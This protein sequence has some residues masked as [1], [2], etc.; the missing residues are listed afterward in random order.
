MVFITNLPSSKAF[1]S[2]FMMADQLTK[3]AYFMPC[4]KTVTGEEIVKLFMD[5]IYKYYG[6]FDNLVLLH[7]GFHTYNLQ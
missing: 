1:D 6:L 4:N 5:N 3:M 2:F 7:H